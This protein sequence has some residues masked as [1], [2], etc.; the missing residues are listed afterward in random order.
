[1]RMDSY[2]TIAVINWNTKDYLEKCLDSIY[3][4]GASY[5]FEVVVVDNL[6]SDGSQQMVKAR[7][8]QTKLIE[9]QVNLGY[10]KAANRVLSQVDSK[11]VL[12]LNSDVEMFPQ[13]IDSMIDFAEKNPKAGVIGP[14]L[15]N[16]DGSLQYSCRNFPS[17]KSGALHAMTGFLYSNNPATKEYKLADWDHEKEREVDWLSGACML[18]RKD[19]VEKV[20]FFDGNYFMYA[21]DM[22]L[23]YRLK[24]GGWVTYYNP[25][26]KV[27]HY[28]G[29]SSSYQ[30]SRM[31][32]GHHKSI[33]KFCAK[34]YKGFTKVVIAVGLTVRAAVLIIANIFRGLKSKIF[35]KRNRRPS[36][37]SFPSL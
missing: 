34:Q 19:A 12:L 21:E 37:N 2:L 36:S 24:Q 20:G 1:M 17:F 25:E 6:S 30:P 35:K 18:L 5:P 29:A 23:C 33:Y 8:P 31:L 26:S 7:Y 16:H 22:D 27:C 13:S 15:L 32:I 4:T 3:K 10:G 14:M 11:Y 9:S 28:I